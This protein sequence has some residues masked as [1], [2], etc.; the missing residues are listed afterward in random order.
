MKQ[1]RNIFLVL[2]FVTMVI[3]CSK[4]N[5]KHDFYL[6]DGEIIYLGRVD[7]AR[8]LPGENRFL[9]RYWI[10]DLRATQLKIFWNQ[11]TDSLIVPIPTHQPADSIDVLIGDATS[12]IP[13]GN[14]TFQIV[15]S[16]GDGLESIIFE[17]LGNVYGENFRMTLVDRFVR[18]LDYDSD[19]NEIA[20]N[21]GAP[22]SSREIGVEI[23]YYSEDK[24]NILHLTSEQLA[25]QTVLENVNVEKGVSYR[26]MFLPEP[27]AIDTFYTAPVQLEIIQNV[28]LNKPVRTSSV[29]SAAYG[30][31]NAVDGIA[32]AASRWISSNA[33]GLEHWIEVDLEKEYS[34]HS[35]MLHKHLYNEFLIPNFTFQIQ[36]DG[37]WIDLVV[38]EDYVGEIYEAVFSEEVVTDKVR[39]FIPVYQNNMARVYELGVYVKY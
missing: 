37:E 32:T 15:S 20:I 26:T 9:L 1:K 16:D 19:N 29:L 5:D 6:Q 23:T 12:S 30:G 35:F 17:R 8:I 36:K 14:Y 21:W 13:E 33:S 31:S 3:G 22:S 2:L 25:L 10:T 7:S 27:T 34:L 11:M 4:M 28:A 38:V 18:N 24:E 39:I